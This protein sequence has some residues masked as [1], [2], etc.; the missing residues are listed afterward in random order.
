MILGYYRHKAK[1]LPIETA[2]W[3]QLVAF[4]NIFGEDH[5]CYLF[6]PLFLFLTSTFP[7]VRSLSLLYTM[8]HTLCVNYSLFFFFCVL[9]SPQINRNKLST[10]KLEL[11]IHFFPLYYFPLLFPV[12]P[13]KKVWSRRPSVS[14]P[15][16]SQAPSRSASNVPQPLF[17][18]PL[19]SLSISLLLPQPRGDHAPSLLGSRLLWAW[20]D[21]NILNC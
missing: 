14:K 9:T 3:L 7:L 1:S 17:S 8:P 6:L 18:L 4:A 10:A 16:P 13:I 21:I 20:T 11:Q 2:F 5:P 12:D 19:L 15:T